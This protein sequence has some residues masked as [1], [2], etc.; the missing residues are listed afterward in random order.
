VAETPEPIRNIMRRTADAMIEDDPVVGA[1]YRAVADFLGE[2]L[3]RV[4]AAI[5]IVK[6]LRE[7]LPRMDTTYISCPTLRELER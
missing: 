6:H 4:I 5:A 7:A 2:D 3:R 1:H